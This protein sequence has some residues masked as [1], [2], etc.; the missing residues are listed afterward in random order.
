MTILLPQS[1]SVRITGVCYPDELQWFLVCLGNYIAFA[2]T[3]VP[4]PIADTCITLSKEHIR[5]H[6]QVSPPSQTFSN[7][8]SIFPSLWSWQLRRCLRR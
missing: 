2:M 1:P 7:H 4:N 5:L 6:A 3:V 8:L